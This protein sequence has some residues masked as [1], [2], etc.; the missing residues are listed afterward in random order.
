M[1]LLY[2]IN[3]WSF[4]TTLVL[5]LTIYFGLI[6]QIFLGIIQV[7]L[8]I[9]IFFR[10]HELTPAIKKHLLGY[11]IATILYGVIFFIIKSYLSTYI[12]LIYFTVLPMSLAGYFLYLTYKAQKTIP[13][14][15]DIS[16]KTVMQ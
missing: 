8:A 4:I 11:S 7:I 9:L 10:W 14:Q 2:Q 5:Y 13:N 3:K 12:G 16:T 1:K 15:T 6:A